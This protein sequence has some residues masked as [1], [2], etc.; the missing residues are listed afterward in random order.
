MAEQHNLTGWITAIATGATAFLT[1]TGGL[2]AWLALRRERMRELPVVERS[3]RWEG[4]YLLLSLTVRNRLAETIV[5]DRIDVLS[6][7]GATIT[8]PT[9]P[10]DLPYHSPNPP[11]RGGTSRL[12]PGYHVD[13]HGRPQTRHQ[14]GDTGYW[15]FA[16]WP[17]PSWR[18]GKVTVAL[19]ISSRADTIRNRRL[20]IKN[21]IA[22]VP[23]VQ[24]DA[25]AN[26]S[27]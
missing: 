1:G 16:I 24:T 22:V 18:S 2:A 27:G 13:P 7:S 23:K 10:G 26:I 5:L 17:A 15:S 8:L 9:S 12:S 11:I 14:S 21:K 4:D 25:N 20:V 3:L 6:P 19:R